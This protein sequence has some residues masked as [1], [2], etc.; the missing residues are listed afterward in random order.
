MK[1]FLSQLFGSSRTAPRRASR[2]N[3]SPRVETLDDRCVPA[4][5]QVQPEVV[6]GQLINDLQ[7]TGTELNDTIVIHDNHNLGGEI[8]VFDNLVLKARYPSASIQEITA[9]LGDG[10]DTFEYHLDS[11]YRNYKIFDVDL[12]AGDDIANFYMNHEIRNTLNI[13]VQGGA[14]ND[15]VWSQ[16]GRVNNATMSFGAYL[17]AGDDR[18]MSAFAGD[19]VGNAHAIVSVAGESGNDTLAVNAP[20]DP[21]GN[22]AL[23][24]PRAT[25]EVN[26]YGGTGNDS[27]WFHHRGKN[28]GKVL[29]T[30]NG[31]EGYN[32]GHADG[33]DNPAL[34]NIQEI[35]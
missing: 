29:V 6:Q 5:V 14:G 16:F 24:D 2:C 34:L 9:K 11:D 7:I 4:S 3:I 12:G 31:E 30:L 13:G 19:L 21:A 32:Y 26:L 33:V 1:R 17:G 10:S 18:F 8:Q 15:V 35:R 23:T 28:Y 20:N 22:V 25:L 27:L